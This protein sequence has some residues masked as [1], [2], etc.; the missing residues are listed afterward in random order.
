[1]ATA[2]TIA[3]ASGAVVLAVA[4][5][6]LAQG[7]VALVQPDAVR[8]FLGRFAGTSNAH[9][10]EMAIR[11]A[12]GLGF[13]FFAPFS[14]CPRILATAGFL[15]LL[16]SAALLFVPWRLHRRF[17]QWAVPMA[18]GRMAPFGIACLAAGLAIVYATFSGDV[19]N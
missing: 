18:T 1:M 13:V 3:I 12:A 15:L 10:L 7:V 2:L 19:A 17:A 5:F 6:L 8:A 11:I 16:T 9:F 14:G 4:G